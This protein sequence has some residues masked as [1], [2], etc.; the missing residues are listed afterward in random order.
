MK[1]M[2]ILEHIVWH[3]EEG[4]TFDV[5]LSLKDDIS[6]RGINLSPIS[7]RNS[8]I[9]K[10]SWKYQERSIVLESQLGPIWGLSSCDQKHVVVIHTKDKIIAKSDEIG[11]TYYIRELVIYNLDG[12]INKTVQMPD[13]LTTNEYR[14]KTFPSA[15]SPSFLY[16]RWNKI[17]EN[18]YLDCVDIHYGRGQLESR[19]LNVETGKIERLLQGSTR[20]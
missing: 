18:T 17:S 15:G 10:I 3:N 2:T 13:L 14:G 4:E 16:Y 7:F 1:D 19:L 6:L 9:N 11:D 8:I 12:S 5:D 20:L